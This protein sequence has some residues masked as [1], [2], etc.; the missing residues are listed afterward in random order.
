MA[1]RQL[2]RCL[3]PALW[4]QLSKQG[5]SSG[6]SGAAAAAGAT[7][8]LSTHQQA[9]GRSQPLFQSL[10]A[11]MRADAQRVY[12]GQ[13]FQPSRLYPKQHKGSEAAAFWGLVG[14]N[15]GVA[16]VAKADSGELKQFLSQHFR[17]SVAAVA[18]GRLHTLLASSI[19]HTSA[20][21]CGVNLLLLG[22]FRHTQPLSAAEVSREGWVMDLAAPTGGLAAG[23]WLGTCKVWR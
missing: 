10:L 3:P 7:G 18:D 15:V 21:H 17:A 9:A 8:A 19:C 16:L 2:S 13:A 1:V 23:C 12:H 11:C 5:S 6:G 20:V 22:L 4:Q 14:L